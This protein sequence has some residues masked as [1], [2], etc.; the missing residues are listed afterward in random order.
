MKK[1]A[2]VVSIRSV[3]GLFALAAAVFCGVSDVAVASPAGGRRCRPV[4]V[5]IGHGFPH[6]GFV[7]SHLT[8]SRTNCQRA[9]TVAHIVGEH[10]LEH[11]Q[12]P[13]DAC[14]THRDCNADGFTCRGRLDPTRRH[15][16]LERCTHNRALITWSERDIDD[17]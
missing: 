1:Y 15:A 3:G 12:G 16:E 10:V 14:E 6:I 9:R 7:A 4:T 13:F 17:A 8:A 5:H 11:A 2:S